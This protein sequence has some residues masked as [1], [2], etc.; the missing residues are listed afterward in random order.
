ME[1]GKIIES[2]E[3]LQK[4]FHEYIHLP[5]GGKEIVCPYWMN[6]LKEG[7]YGPFGGKGLP[8]QIVE[9]TEN[10]AKPKGVDLA[11]M[12]EREVLD[13]MEQERIGVDCSGFVF[14]MLDSLDKEK[15]GNGIANDI[16][17][18]K[19]KVLECRANVAMLTDENITLPIEKVAEV[20]VGDMIRLGGGK[21]VAIVVGVTRDTQDKGELKEIEYAHS[22]AKTK[23]FGVHSALIKIIDPQGGLETQEW[24]EETKDGKNYGDSNFLPLSGDGLKRLKIWV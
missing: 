21:H 3:A 14:W 17:G 2:S 5:L 1:K 13:F 22:S 4:L 9:A 12:S 16:P 24:S 6:D 19:G 23:E 20:R 8:E 11:K 10:A 15:G 7:I 18:C